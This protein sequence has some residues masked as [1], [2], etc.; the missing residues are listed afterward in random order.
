[1]LPKITP[2]IAVLTEHRRRM[3]GQQRCSPGRRVPAPFTV[4]G[5]LFRPELSLADLSHRRWP[6]EIQAFLTRALSP[7]EG[8][9]GVLCEKVDQ[10]LAF[11]KLTHQGSAGIPVVGAVEIDRCR[12]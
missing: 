3:L 8:I 7:L 6:E 2:K 5:I 11:N 10:V 12:R 4:D 9:C 1:M